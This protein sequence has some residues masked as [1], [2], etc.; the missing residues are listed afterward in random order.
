M[1]QETKKAHEQEVFYM[2]DT[3]AAKLLCCSPSKLRNDRSLGRGL[4][5][6]K[7]GRNILYKRSDLIN[8][9][10]ATRITPRNQEAA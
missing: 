8:A 9:V 1:S 2:R 4:P 10:E 6:S 3:E 7:F 5:Y